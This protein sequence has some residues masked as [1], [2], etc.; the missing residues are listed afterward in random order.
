MKRITR[1][2]T[3]FT[4]IYIKKLVTNMKT[5]R[6]GKTELSERMEKAAALFGI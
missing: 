1:N 6:L 5:R 4:T 2:D 3:M